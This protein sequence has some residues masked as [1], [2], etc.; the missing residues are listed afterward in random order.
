MEATKD[1]NAGSAQ[2]LELVKKEPA[3]LYLSMEALWEMESIASRLLD[4][5]QSVDVSDLWVRGAVARINK[6]ARLAAGAL[7]DEVEVVSVLEARLAGK[8]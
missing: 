4:W 7:H 5:S 3:R 1:F 2:A 8:K 6:L